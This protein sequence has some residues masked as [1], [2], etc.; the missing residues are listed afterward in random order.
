[1]VIFGEIETLDFAP[2]QTPEIAL[3]STYIVWKMSIRFSA[4]NITVLT[5]TL[6]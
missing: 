5:V 4:K 3:I 2:M 1:M 6:C